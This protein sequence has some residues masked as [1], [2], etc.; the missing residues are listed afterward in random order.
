MQTIEVKTQPT[1]ERNVALVVARLSNF[2]FMG[3]TRGPCLWAE[4]FNPNGQLFDAAHIRI[5]GEAWQNWPCD[6][7][8]EQDLEYLGTVIVNKLGLL[9]RNEVPFFKSFIDSLSLLEGSSGAF[10]ANV[11]GYPDTF[12]YQWKKNNNNIVNQT[13]LSYSFEAVTAED[14][15]NYSV[16]VTNGIGTITGHASLSVVEFS[17]PSIVV[18][19]ENKSF[20]LGSQGQIY[21]T[22][23]GIPAPT[24]IWSKNGQELANFSGS[25]LYFS[26]FQIENTGIYQVE[27]SNIEGSILSNEAIVTINS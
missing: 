9:K 6:L 18:N 26:D 12:S 19:L 15:G 17:A 24:F 1:A 16:V 3:P 25:S 27:I 14:A 23:E 2:D 10:V 4:Q 13:G 22:V 8:E 20:D 5:D 7:T 21:V 11:G